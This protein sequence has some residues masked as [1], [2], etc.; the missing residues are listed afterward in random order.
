MRTAGTIGLL[1]SLVFLAGCFPIVGSYYRLERQEAKYF[2]GSCNGNVGPPS[3]VFFPFHGVFLSA[4]VNE[5]PRLVL[6]GIHVPEGRQ[7]Q[8]LDRTLRITDEESGQRKSQVVPLEPAR[9]RGGNPDPREFRLTTDPFG[10]EDYFGVM[11]GETRTV[12]L[13]FGSEITGHKTYRFH[14]KLERQPEAGSITFPRVSIDGVTYDGPNLPFKK[15]S[16]LE[17]SPINC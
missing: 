1:T 9:L 3:G 2:G 7:V 6:I 4:S 14:A 12:K 10:R 16:H 5:V 8:I 13:L 11:R 15:G 17:I